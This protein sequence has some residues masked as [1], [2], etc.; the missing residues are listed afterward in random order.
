M[1]RLS[2]MN[3]TRVGLTGQGS[4]GMRRTWCGVVAF[5]VLL[6]AGI[7][8]AADAPGFAAALQSWRWIPIPIVGGVAV[9]LPSVEIALAG[10]WLLGMGRTCVAWLA[11]AL[12]GL[13]TAVYTAQVLI[14]GPPPCGCFGG[15][16]RYLASRHEAIAVLGR[17]VLLMLLLLVSQLPARNVQ[18]HG[19]A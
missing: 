17:N 14:A 16:E 8:K 1:E 2:A 10:A 3:Q 12:V 15:L 5:V 4:A 13:F 7:L 11:L 6:A 19:V 9:L 18:S